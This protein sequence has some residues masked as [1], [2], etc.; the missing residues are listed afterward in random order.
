M[1]SVTRLTLLGAALLV[2]LP[3][4]ATAQPPY[5]SELVGFNGPPINDPATSKEMFRQ[6]DFSGSSAQY[7]I[8]N[9]VD[10]NNPYSMHAAYRSSVHLTEGDAGLQ[11]FFNWVDPADPDAWV[12]LSTFNGPERPNPSLHTEGKV[13]FKLKNRSQLFSGVIGVCIGIRETGVEVPQLADGGTG[14]DIEW[15]GVDTTPNGIIAG[16]DGI[17]DT[18]AAGDDIQVYPLGYDIDDPNDPLPSGTAVVDPGPDGILD[19][20]PGNDD[21]IRFGYFIDGEGVRRPIPAVNLVP[22]NAFRQMEFDL[23]TGA[24]KV[25]GV[26]LGGGIAGFTGNGILDVTPARGTLEHI[27][28]TNNLADTAQLIDLGIDELYFTSPEADPVVAPKVVAP[29]IRDDTEVTVTGLMQDVYKVRLYRDDVLADTITL[30]TGAPDYPPEEVVFTLTPPALADE[31]FTATQEVVDGRVSEHSAPVYALP[32]ASPYSFCIVIDEDGDGSCTASP[33][34]FVPTTDAGIYSGNPKPAGQPIF[35]DDAVWQTIDIPLTDQ[36]LVHGWQGQGGNG[37]I[38]PTGDILTIDTLWFTMSA[39]PEYTGQHEAYIDSMQALDALGD[40]VATIHDMEDGVNYMLYP[41]GQSTTSPTSSALSSTATF[42]GLTAHRLLWSYPDPNAEY[43]MG[44]YHNVGYACNT[45]PGFPSTATTVRVRLLARGPQLNPDAPL[46]TVQAPLVLGT[47]PLDTVRVAHDPNAVSVSLYVNGELAATENAPDGTEVDFTGL[48]LAVGDSVSAKQ[49]FTDVG[50]SDFAYPHAVDDAPLPPAVETPI[51]PDQAAIELTGVYDY[52]YATASE[53]AVYVNGVL[54]GTEVPTGDTA[55]VPI[56]IAVTTGDEVTATQTV[57]GLEGP[58]SAPVIVGYPAPVIFKAPAQGDATVRVQGFHPDATEA[59]VVV[60]DTTE[61]SAAIPVGAAYVE[62]PVSGLVMG[63]TVTAY[64]TAG[65]VTSAFAVPE[66]VTTN[67]QTVLICDDFEYDEATYLTE[68]ADSNPPRLELV[69]DRNATAPM[70]EKSLYSAP[71]AGRV[72]QDIADTV[73]TAT[74]PVIWNVHIYDAYGPGTSNVQFAQ[75]NGH[76]D[77]FFSHVGMLSWA[78]QDTDYYQ[79]RVN[80]NGGPNWLDMTEYDSPLRSVGW[81][82]FTVVYKGTLVDAYIDGA[83]AA[84]NIELSVAPI[85]DRARIGGGYSSANAAWYDD[86]CVEIGSVRFEPIGPQPPPPPTVPQ[87]LFAGDQSVTVTDVMDDVS[88]VEIVDESAVVIGTYAGAVDESGVVEVALTRPLLNTELITARVTN[89]VGTESSFPATE[90]GKRNGDILISLGIRETGDTGPLGSPGGSGGEIE[91]IG[92]A[93][94]VEG[95]PQGL[96]VSP[97][98]TWQTI[99]FDPAG[100]VSGFTGDGNITVNFGVI[101]HLAVAVDSNS[102]DRSVGPYRLYVD[103]VINV[104]A[105]NGS[106]FVIT[107]FEGYTLGSDVLFMHPRFSGS[108]DMDLAVSPSV[109]VASDVYGNPSQ[110]EELQ[111]MWL[112]T[113]PQRW[114]RIT[115]YQATNVAR[116]IIDLTKPV[117]MDILLVEECTQQGDLNGDGAIDLTDLELFEACF[118]GPWIK[119]DPACNC[120]DMNDDGRVDV[121][122]FAL[123]QAAANN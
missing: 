114:A 71:G 87:P 9:D 111:W 34:E 92:A 84:K 91:W 55:S 50:E 43:A 59:T 82:T 105:D 42:D 27:A 80:G 108:T 115:T 3:A 113:T 38:E 37:A 121:S 106:D 26:D 41:R 18:A 8:S 73:P 85:F 86:F 68:W 5:L 98:N 6:P 45:A 112:D 7:I 28:F 33:L 32:E 54:A 70:G 21:E 52:P 11:V 69:S 64:Q 120:A 15:V 13:F 103:N 31:K 119:T 107:D 102:P 14:G 10:P 57:N 4:A 1:K 63:D 88:L 97:S 95:A 116:P 93:S 20:T 61:F 49:T 122:D 53:V 83:L 90:V 17:V 56:A 19:T 12:R 117:Q 81:H 35:T 44:L 101:E 109:S 96:P 100:P 72:E 66:T 62:V 29:I 74:E 94:V 60:N 99:I 65:V 58:E 22:N 76:A 89:V 16:P 67:A 110:A 25:D 79:L 48:T 77:W 40:V 104:L 75:L 51:A 39:S 2:M 46:P 30:D 36:S 23:S 47:L 24:V 78:P 118:A 123:L